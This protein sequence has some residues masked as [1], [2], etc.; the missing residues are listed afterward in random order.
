MKPHKYAKEIIHWANGGGVQYLDLVNSD[1]YDWRN[2]TD[3][4]YMNF[5]NPNIE[6]R[7]KPETLR[8]R[9]AYLESVKDKNYAWMVTTDYQAK[10]L[11]ESASFIKWLTDWTEV[12]I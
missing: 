10:T 8:Y 7:I 2:V 11:E 9:V 3:N 5:N 12:E 4:S 1:K 6:W